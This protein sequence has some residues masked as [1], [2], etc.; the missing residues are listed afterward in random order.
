MVT[1][2]T[3]EEESLAAE[4][5]LLA[6]ACLVSLVVALGD[7][8]K[9]LEACATLLCADPALSSSPVKVR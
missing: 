3:V 8:E 1:D 5:S 4:L 6:S 2:S 7:T 9:M